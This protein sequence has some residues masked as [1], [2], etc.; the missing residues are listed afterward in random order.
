MP[1]KS[2]WSASMLVTTTM[3]GLYWTSDPSLSSASATKNAPL[4]WWALVPASPRSPPTA[5]D[6]SNPACCSAT[7][8]M[9]VVVVLPA[10]PVTISVVWPAI[11]LASTSGRRITGIP[12]LRASTSSGLVLGMAAWVVTTAVG[13]PG[14][15]SN[16]DGSCPIRIVA[17][18]ARN[19]MTPRDS[20]A[21]EPDTNPPR[22]I[23][24]RAMPLMPAPPMPTMCT[25]R[26]SG[27]RSGAR[28]SE[29]TVGSALRARPARPRVP[30]ARPA[31]RRRDARP[32]PRRSSSPRAVRNRSAAPPRCRR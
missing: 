19:A 6:G 14:S 4:P 29:L 7:M 22:S 27:G 5:K 16:E 17:P 20:L 28:P 30:R 21:S 18:R 31:R 23:R 1:K 13:P 12:R 15:R 24:M 10:V 25:R 2:R 32:V 3:S 8:S 11:S 9:D 26:S